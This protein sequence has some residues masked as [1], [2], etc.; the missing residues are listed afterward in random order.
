M[1][2]KLFANKWLF[3][4]VA[5]EIKMPNKPYNSLKLIFC[6]LLFFILN[7]VWFLMKNHLYDTLLKIS[8]K[9]NNKN[10]IFDSNV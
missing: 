10:I 7:I 9:K 5:D 8:D 3:F 2:N 1:S 6:K 4:I